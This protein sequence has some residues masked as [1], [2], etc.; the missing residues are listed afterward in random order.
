MVITLVSCHSLM[1]DYHVKIVCTIDTGLTGK[2]P[3]DE[4]YFMLCLCFHQNCSDLA[5]ALHWNILFPA[6]SII[7]SCSA[8]KILLVDHQSRWWRQVPGTVLFA[9]VL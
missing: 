3:K 9:R 5:V 7:N 8:Q 2:Q 1:G 6:V 4:E